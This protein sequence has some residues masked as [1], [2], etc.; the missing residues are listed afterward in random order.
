MKKWFIFIFEWKH[1]IRNPFKV[2]ALVLFFASA[3]YGI[4][5]G[6]ELFEQQNQKIKTIKEIASEGAKEINAYYQKGELGPTDH[7]WVDVTTPFWAMWYTSTYAYK[8]PLP[9]MIYSIGQAEQYGFYKKLTFNSSV[10]DTDMVEE[11]ANPKRLQ[12]G[13][14]D[15]SSSILF[16]SPLLLLILT[17]HLKANEAENGVLPLIQLQITSKSA[18]LISRLLFYLLLQSAIILALIIYGALQGQISLWIN[19][20]LHEVIFYTLTYQ[21]LWAVIY[22]IILSKSITVLASSISMTGIFLLLT[23]IVPG[24]IHQMVSIKF[25]V[26]NML[27]Y[28]D[29]ERDERWALYDESDSLITSQLINLIPEIETSLANQDSLV[30][31]EVISRSYSLLINEMIKERAVEIELENERRNEWI[32]QWNW[33]NPLTFFQNQLNKAAGT[34]FNN[35]KVYK[36]QIQAGIDTQNNLM[37]KDIWNGVLVDAEKYKDYRT[38]IVNDGKTP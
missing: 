13:T 31:H 33:L 23:F 15:F 10:Y 12:I 30:S 27:D 2:L 16:L 8:T 7:P 28:I 32:N 34:H 36:E 25:P 1:F 19:T 26:N 6:V 21:I 35:Y 37:V 3:I 11:I 17:Y 4:N 14:L 9:T 18:W 24:I 5:N 38:K 22:Y 29:T 20:P